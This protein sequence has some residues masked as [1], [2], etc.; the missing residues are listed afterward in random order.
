MN[1]GMS[2]AVGGLLKKGGAKHKHASSMGRA[3]AA[4]PFNSDAKL[5]L[6]VSLCCADKAQNTLRFLSHRTW[7]NLRDL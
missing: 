1:E 2:A 3:R 6:C 7:R 5:Q 4:N